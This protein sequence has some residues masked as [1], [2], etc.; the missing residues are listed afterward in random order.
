MVFSLVVA[1]GG[2][3]VFSGDALF[4]LDGSSV[5]GSATGGAASRQ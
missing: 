1:N 4:G 3:M 2:A 5:G